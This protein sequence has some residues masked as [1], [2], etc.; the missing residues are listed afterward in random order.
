MIFNMIT[1]GS[2]GGGDNKDY[3]KL[4]LRTISAASGSMS[5][6]GDYAFANCYKLTTVSFPVATSIGYNAFAYCSA[7]ATANFPAATSIGSYA[8]ASCSALTTA[9]FPV[10]TSIGPYAFAYCSALATVSFPVVTSIDSN[11]FNRCSALT[12]AS[13]PAARTIGSFAFQSCY[14]LLSLYLMGSSITQLAGSTAFASTPISSY[15]AQTGGVNGSIFV[16]ASLYDS[17]ISKAVWSRYSSRF[18]SV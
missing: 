16:P 9:S 7:L 11:A 10:A 17:Y 2:G 1:K 6:I 4:V 18:V 15:T 13:F 12:T 14:K 3:E 5:K 8:F